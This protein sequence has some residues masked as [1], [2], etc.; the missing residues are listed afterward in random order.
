V[1]TSVASTNRGLGGS[2]LLLQ[3]A[4][5]SLNNQTT[6]P[7]LV[8]GRAKGS[9]ARNKNTDSAGIKQRNAVDCFDLCG[10]RNFQIVERLNG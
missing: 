3:L 1:L 4:I 8:N 6:P 5:I 10:Q 2:S 7:F 9:R